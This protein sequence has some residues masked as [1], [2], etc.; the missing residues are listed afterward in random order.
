MSSEEEAKLEQ[1]N[2][3]NEKENEIIK[4]IKR[5]VRFWNLMAH[6]L[7]ALNVIIALTA[8]IASITVASKILGENS[9]YTSI[10]AYLAAISSAMLASFNLTEK[11]NNVKIAWRKLNAA[12]WKYGLNPDSEAAKLVDS[13]YEG[14]TQIGDITIKKDGV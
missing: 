12:S 6:A 9:Y 1:R 7:R 3:Q 11:S 2:A 10:A 5:T 13:W 4:E 8:I 14:E